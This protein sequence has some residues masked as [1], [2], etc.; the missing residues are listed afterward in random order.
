MVDD[1]SYFL[2]FFFLSENC[3]QFCEHIKILVYKLP[4]KKPGKQHSIPM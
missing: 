1:V 2:F 4:I 3:I